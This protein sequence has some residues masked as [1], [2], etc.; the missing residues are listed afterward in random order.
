MSDFN[1]TYSALAR[2]AERVGRDEAGTQRT[3][4]LRAGRSPRTFRYVPTEAHR[5]LV[6]G[7]A[8]LGRGQLTPEEAMSLLHYGE[9]AV[10]LER[11][12]NAPHHV[13]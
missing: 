5:A 13:R 4:H 1:R 10:A 7:M 9:S 3:S 2:A 8:K 12:R 11:A 6:D